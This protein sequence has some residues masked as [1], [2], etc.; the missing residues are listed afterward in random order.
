M[1]VL[2]LIALALTASA[3]STTGSSV[4][5]TQY[6][7]I[8]VT[9][10]GPCPDE[11]TYNRLIASR[12]NPL[13][14]QTKPATGVERNA[15]TSAQLGLYEAPGKWAD[16]VSAALDRCQATVEEREENEGVA[17]KP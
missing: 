5:E 14:N 4:V 15:R 8:T 12:P 10:R 7:T 13:R 17:D 3:C 16:K 6:K 1:R 2:A 11:A 9:K